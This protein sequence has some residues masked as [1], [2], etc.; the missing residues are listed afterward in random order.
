[1]DYNKFEDRISSWI[2]GDLDLKDRK[3]FEVFLARTLNIN[4]RWMRCV[5]LSQ[6]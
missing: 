4:K 3:E 5:I 2:E 1:M 6:E